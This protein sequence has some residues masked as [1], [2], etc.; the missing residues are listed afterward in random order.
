M[1]R[2]WNEFTP[3]YSQK[4]AV[5]PAPAGKNLLKPPVVVVANDLVSAALLCEDAR[6]LK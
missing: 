6:L 1:N 4:I 5:L 3:L 2:F